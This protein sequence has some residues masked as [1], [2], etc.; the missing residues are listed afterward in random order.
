MATTVRIG[1]IRHLEAFYCCECGNR[2]GWVSIGE[3]TADGIAHCD[4]CAK[5]QEEEAL[6]HEGAN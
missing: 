4:E 2:L 6:E 1:D 5:S 3:R